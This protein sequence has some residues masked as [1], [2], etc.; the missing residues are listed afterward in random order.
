MRIFIISILFLVMP[1]S[2]MAKSNHRIDSL[3]HVLD[4]TIEEKKIYTEQKRNII[5]DLQNKIQQTPS[6]NAKS[7][8]YIQLFEEYKGFQ[9]DSALIVAQEIE[10][11]AND[12]NLDDYKIYSK[13]NFAEVMIVTGMYKEALDILDSVNDSKQMLKEHISYRYHLYHSLY[14][15]MAQYSF[16]E[17][18]KKEYRQLEY[19]YKDSILSL[20]APE[21]PNYQ[22]VTTTKLAMEGK[23]DEALKTGYTLFEK[24]LNDTHILAMVSHNMSE[25]YKLKNDEEN[26]KIFLAISA[27][28]DIKSGVK[29]YRSLPELATILYN[30]GDIDRAYNYMQCSLDDAIFCKARLRTIQMSQTLP[31]VNEAYNVKM[32]HEQNR[33]RI[34]IT[35]VILLAISLIIGIIYIYRKLKELAIARREVK[36]AYENL[37]AVNQELKTLNNDLTESNHIKEEY[38]S[39]VFTMCSSYIDKLDDFRKRVNR[40]I[41]VGQVDDLF[42]E[43]QSSTLVNDELKDFYKSFDTIFLN[44]YPN[45]VEEFNSLLDEEDQLIAKKGELLT[46]ELRIYALIKLGIEDSVKIASFLHYSTQTVYNYRLKIRT[47]AKKEKAEL[48][49]I[50]KKL[51]NFQQ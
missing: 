21:D 1:F 25:I 9:M 14:I 7:F 43:T 27:I 34:V 30:D 33:L 40:K 23:F 26:R 41:K 10:K 35:I 6:T 16:I 8:F 51:G 28:N 32:Q 24:S 36:I 37:K 18:E 48:I 20:L 47:K 50:V 4:K 11:M 38:I 31:I 22:M 3:L 15:L 17:K 49:E 44:I 39:Y 42:K 2:I 29:E 12:L 19:Q 46:P 5:K 13:L 45:F